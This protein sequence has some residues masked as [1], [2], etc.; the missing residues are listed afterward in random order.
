M[1]RRFGKLPPL[2]A[3]E[4][5]E[6]AARLKSFSL[7]AEELNITQSAVSHQIR[8]LED[9]FS[10]SLFNRVGRSVELTTAGYDFLQ[11]TTDVLKALARGKRRL[12]F[13]FRPGSVVW[14]AT[15]GFASKWLL[16]RYNKL[17]EWFPE[18]QPWLFST[19]E[20]YDL[21][22][23]E[24]DL[25]I[26][27]GDGLWPGVTATKLFHDYLTPMLSPAYFKQHATM[28]SIEEMENLPLIHDERSDDWLAWYNQIGEERE[29]CVSGSVFSDPALVL[30]AAATGQGIGLGSLLMA[31][32]YLESGALV[33][34]FK[35]IIKSQ[36]AYYLVYNSND[37]MRPSVKKAKDWL[38]Q[39]VQ[40]FIKMMDF[41]EQNEE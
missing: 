14:G 1:S 7:A 41:D 3:L 10:M 34:P 21:E 32:E 23:Q 26:W 19:D 36:H 28:T 12:D 22:S 35:D 31:N 38:I 29:D 11:T 27:Y 9:F 39:E 24:V 6:S 16:P 30:E 17:R 37:P 15:P 33:R 4:G 8:A 18:V 2:T 20:T 40:N 25:A 13:Y 5:F